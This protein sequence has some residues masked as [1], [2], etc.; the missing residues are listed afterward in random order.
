MINGAK[1]AAAV[2]ASRDWF[3]RTGTGSVITIGVC[4]TCGGNI[5]LQFMGPVALPMRPSYLAD[6]VN[7]T[8]DRG[9]DD[10]IPGRQS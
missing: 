4:D 8:C 10:H 3:E 2:I 5:T 1:Y 7:I 9:G 6:R